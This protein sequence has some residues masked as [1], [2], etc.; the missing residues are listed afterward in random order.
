MIRVADAC[1]P[2][3]RPR[4]R[5]RSLAAPRLARK[6]RSTPRGLSN[7]TSG[8]NSGGPSR[9]GR[10]PMTIATRHASISVP[11]AER[12]CQREAIPG[13]SSIS[14]GAFTSWTG[15]SATA[16]TAGGFSCLV[17][18]VRSLPFR[19][20]FCWPTGYQGSD[21]LG[22]NE[23][24]VPDSPTRVGSSCSRRLSPTRGSPGRHH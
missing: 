12:S 16:S 4:Q 21:G 9:P 1:C 18:Q 23:S 14:S 3:F 19:D 17:S 5:A 13:G 10:S 15:P 8:P 2:Q 7:A 22:G 11:R 6:P 24:P 20:L